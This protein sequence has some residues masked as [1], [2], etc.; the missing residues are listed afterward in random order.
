MSQRRALATIW[1]V[2]LLI[3]SGVSAAWG[4]DFTQRSVSRSRQFIVYCPDVR[5]RMAVTGFVETA[6][7]AVLDAVGLRDHW[8]LPI[9][10]NLE[11]PATSNPG[12][13]LCRTRLINTEEGCKVEIDIALRTEQFKEVYF[14]QQIVRAILLEIAYR[15]HP[16]ADGAPYANPP[17][18]LVEGLSERFQA[19]A[20]STRPDAA[21]FKQLID[22][23]RLPTA[24]DF[25]ASNVDVMD[26]TSRTVYGACA[27]SLMDMLLAMPNGSRNFGK[28]IL[29]LPQFDGDSVNLLFKH[30]PELGTNDASLEKWWT[31]GIARN[32]A[33]ER[34]LGMTVPETDAQL[35]SLLTISIVT[36]EKSGEKTSFELPD[37]AKFIKLRTAQAALFKQSN[38]LAALLPQAH[39]LLRPVVIEYQR[40][41]A[42]LARG[43][44]HR[45]DESLREI[46]NYRAMIVERIDK[47]ADYLNWFE[48]TQ[49]PE[50]SGAFDSY[51]KAATALENSAPPKRDDAITRY[52]DQVEREF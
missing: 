41:V 48:A 1:V 35:S 20:T 9:I 16:P 22:T 37:Y 12:Q 27:S 47:I 29:D 32:S 25:L 10:V 34:Y 8:K 7:S 44:T 50:R 19:Q 46:G 45:T 26:S 33:S 38:A 15:D 13:P 24:R 43:K 42:E 17:A 6:K 2:G 52:I 30:F 28:M 21:L 49:M 14:P 4:I 40:I 36:D 18:W 3:L 31:L 51:M 23:G 11:R 39:P 5:L